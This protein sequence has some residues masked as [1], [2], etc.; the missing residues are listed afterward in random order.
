MVDVVDSKST[1]S[2]GVPVRVRSPAPTFELANVG[3]PHICGF[4]FD[5][6]DHYFS[7]IFCFRCVF[8]GMSLHFWVDLEGHF[9]STG[10]IFRIAL[11]EAILESTSRWV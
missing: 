3:F 8:I 11:A 5:F 10:K 1:A 7:A 4:F 6:F 2:D 9:Y